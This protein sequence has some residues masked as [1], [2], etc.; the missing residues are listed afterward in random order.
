MACSCAPKHCAR[1]PVR[2]RAHRYIAH[3]ESRQSRQPDIG[4]SRMA[5]TA[6]LSPLTT[7]R[8]PGRPASIISAASAIGTPDRVRG[9]R[10]TRCRMRSRARTSTSDHRREIER[11]D[12]RRRLPGLPHRIDVDAGRR[13]RCFAFIKM[14]IPQANSTPRD[15][16]EMSPLARNG[17]AVL[18]ARDRRACLIA[19]RQFEN[20]S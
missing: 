13:L 5:S 17:L 6:S 8:I 18:G 7:L 19:L 1:L 14:R 4:S 2:R 15:R 16:A 12:A 3:G 9:S 10:R 11:G 20:L